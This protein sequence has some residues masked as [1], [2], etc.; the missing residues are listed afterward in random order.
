MVQVAENW[1]R[2]HGRVEAWTAP[3][4]PGEPGRLTLAVDRV[5]TVVSEDG[6]RHRNLLAH[7]AGRT[8][9]VIVPASAMGGIEPRAGTTVAI[10]VRAGRSPG[11]VV[12]H[13]GRITLAP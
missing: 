5:D 1:S 4:A 7:A 11:R 3:Q 2:I 9:E 10:D 6:S 8:V 12:A 13:P